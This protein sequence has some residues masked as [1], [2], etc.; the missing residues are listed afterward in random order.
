MAEAFSRIW[1]LKFACHFQLAAQSA[2]VPLIQPGPEVIKRT[3]AQSEITDDHDASFMPSGKRE[4]AAFQR[5]LYRELPVY[6]N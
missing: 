1:R 6:R 4:W 2:S 5:R 3:L